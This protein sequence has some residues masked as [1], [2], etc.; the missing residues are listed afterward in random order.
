MMKLIPFLIIFLLVVSILCYIS[1]FIWRHKELRKKILIAICCVVVIAI[2]AIGATYIPH[3]II[4]IKPSEVASITISS[5]N[6]S[7]PY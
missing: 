2:S 7:L 1:I 6:L 4:T 5:C 3:K